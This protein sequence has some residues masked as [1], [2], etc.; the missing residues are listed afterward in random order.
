MDGDTEISVA[1]EICGTDA[2]TSV[3]ATPFSPPSLSEF[4]FRRTKLPPPPHPLWKPP[5]PLCHPTS[6]KPIP[7]TLLFPNEQLIVWRKIFHKAFPWNFLIAPGHIFKQNLFNKLEL[8][9]LILINVSGR[10]L[11]IRKN[12]MLFTYHVLNLWACDSD[13]SLLHNLLYQLDRDNYIWVV[14]LFYIE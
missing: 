1:V 13:I 4:A 11:Q 6:G 9:D 7:F 8:E 10:I 2:R 3:L 12:H 14:C 5:P